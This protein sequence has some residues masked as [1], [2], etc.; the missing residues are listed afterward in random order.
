MKRLADVLVQ[1]IGWFGLASLDELS[2]FLSVPDVPDSKRSIDHISY[3]YEPG[4][5][6]QQNRLFYC[7]AD[8]FIVFYM[9]LVCSSKS[10]HKLE[11]FS[12]TVTKKSTA[13]SAQSPLP[14]LPPGGTSRPNKQHT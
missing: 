4:T 1:H 9:L 5:M 2:D 14:P 6:Y 12:R 3:S 11:I 10:P 7:F 13:S 8:L